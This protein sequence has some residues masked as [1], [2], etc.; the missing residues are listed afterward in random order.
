VFQDLTEE[1]GPRETKAL[2]EHQAKEDPKAP[3]VLKE[4]KG[5]W[6]HQAKEDP[7]AP[8]APREIKGLQDHLERQD[9]KALRATKANRALLELSLKK[10]GSSVC[11]IL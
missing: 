5:L 3:W 2:W 7:K 11:G 9:L 4:I 10:T 8:W 6:E 1:M